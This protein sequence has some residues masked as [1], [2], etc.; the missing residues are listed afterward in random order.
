MFQNDSKNFL[1]E[2]FGLG[3]MQKVQGIVTPQL[4]ALGKFYLD[5]SCYFV[6]AETPAKGRSFQHYYSEVSKYL[7]GS[8]ERQKV[9]QTLIQGSHICGITLASLHTHG[10]GELLP[11]QEEVENRMRADI[12][13]AVSKLQA[14]PQEGI[15][16]DK[17]TKCVAR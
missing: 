11:L 3:Y 4:Q 9:L 10:K 14:L 16:V 12:A 17:L 8:E 1:P 13:T 2:I 5:G 6:I 15:V 7:T